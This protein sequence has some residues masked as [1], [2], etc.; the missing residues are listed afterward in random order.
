MPMGIGLGLGPS[1][2]RSGGSAPQ[3][4]DGALGVWYADQYQSSPRRLIPNAM[5]V[6]AAS[7]NLVSFPRRRF[8]ANDFWARTAV[9]VTDNN[10]VAPDGT[11][12][13]STL[14]GTGDCYIFKTQ[15]PVLTAGTYTIA[16][17]VKR[18]AAAVA[19]QSFKME[20]NTAGLA[21]GTLTATSVWQRFYFTAT[22]GAGSQ[23]ILFLR[24]VASGG[25][26]LEV[27]D[28]ALYPGTVTSQEEVF[29]GHMYLG[30]NH[31]T[32][33]PA[34]ASGELDFTADGWASMQF[35]ATSFSRFSIVAVARRTRNTSTYNAIISTPSGYLSLTPMYDQSSS[36][37]SY[38][39]GQALGSTVSLANAMKLYNRG[40]RVHAQVYDGT[41]LNGYLNDA[42]F[43]I[44]GSG[45][46]TQS[47]GDLVA[48]AF[49][50]PTAS[51]YTDY[52]VAA[53]ALYNKALTASEVKTAGAALMAHV[54]GSGISLTDDDLFWIAE[55]DSITVDT[56]AYVRKYGA[57]STQNL[58]GT[59]SA[60]SGSQIA[61]MNTRA[62]GVDACIPSNRGSK[63]FVLS[64]LIGAN[65]LTAAT[66]TTQFLTDLA[67][68]CDARRAAGWKVVLCTLLPNINSGYNAKRNV[69]NT[70]IR[71]WT[72]GGST[73]AGVHA[74]YICDL[75]AD[76]TM[77]PD[78]ASSNTTYYPDG[79]H[80]SD[81]GHTILETV[82]RP[83]MNS[84]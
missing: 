43:A 47:I 66:T 45:F 46:T 76:A 84:V 15:A 8:N 62:A 55:G 3:L 79:V 34:V 80:P 71:L 18:A 27:C 64:V 69:A 53:I 73:I 23:L 70:E 50:S 68:Y 33:A 63:R 1:V 17:S 25:F 67:A 77:G 57:N 29:A 49:Q 44:Q 82:F 52:K 48:G 51:Q 40:W 28:V 22:V 35:P 7:P 20:F 75:A 9:T 24:A 31:F 56:N 39:G 81:A 83:V 37:R 42:K 38:G 72:T 60:V 54:A 58:I 61:T 10:A 6:T 30:P 16:A 59:V 26:N 19:D 65:D 21:S 11:T 4:P 5:A 74:D 13:A 2:L 78:A 41:Q 32:A 12:E 36:F 14:V